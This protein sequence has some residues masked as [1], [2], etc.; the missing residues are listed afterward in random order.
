MQETRVS[1]VEGP[2][3]ADLNTNDWTVRTS[4]NE[5]LKQ[6]VEKSETRQAIHQ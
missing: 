5:N 6:T 1:V 4:A 2:E 3:P